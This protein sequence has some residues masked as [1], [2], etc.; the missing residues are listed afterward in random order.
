MLQIK[1]FEAG[2]GTSILTNEET[3]LIYSP[4]YGVPG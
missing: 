1:L 3:T 2:A 4:E